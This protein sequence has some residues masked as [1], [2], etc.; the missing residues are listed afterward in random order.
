MPYKGQRT[1]RQN[2][3]EF[4]HIVE[5]LLPLGG[6]GM[7][8]NLM[9]DWHRSRGLEIRR[10]TNRRA[11]DRSYVRWCFADGSDAEAFIK[12]Y[13]GTIVVPAARA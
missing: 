2:E 6:F 12:E 8:L 4:P 1:A 10:G 7:T 5:H 11:D 3:R 9:H 13:G